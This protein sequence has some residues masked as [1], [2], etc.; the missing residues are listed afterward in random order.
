MTW[1]Q[2]LPPPVKLWTIYELYGPPLQYMARLSM[3][4]QSGGGAEDGNSIMV[5]SYLETLRAALVA[6]GLQQCLPPDPKDDPMI[7]ELWL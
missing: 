2:M 4:D 7:V 3:I 5:S 1:F 6:R